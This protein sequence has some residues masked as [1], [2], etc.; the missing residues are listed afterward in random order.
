VLP[1]GIL[2]R[3]PG[4][5]ELME[6]EPFLK[7][8]RQASRLTASYGF[9]TGGYVRPGVTVRTALPYGFVMRPGGNG[10]YTFTLYWTYKLLLLR[11]SNRVET[12]AR[13]IAPGFYHAFITRRSR[14]LGKSASDL[15]LPNTPMCTNQRR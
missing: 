8:T 13:W 14:E 6:R 10:S 9:G 2:A 15:P 5:K 1:E 7:G 11:R 4:R 12:C 3:G